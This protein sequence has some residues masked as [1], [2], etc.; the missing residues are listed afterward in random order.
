MPRHRLSHFHR[1]LLV[2]VLYVVRHP[3]RVLI[4]AVLGV[5]FAAGLAWWRLNVSTDQNR[6]F[7]S[8]VPFFK[9]YLAFN[10]DFPE[11]EANYVLVQAKDP[12]HWPAV[13]RWAAVSD[14]ITDA[15]RKRTDAVRDVDNRVPLESLHGQGLLYESHALLKQDLRDTKQLVPLARQWGE[16]PRGIQTLLGP[17][18][19]ERW[20]SGLGLQN[21]P[22]VQAAQLTGLMAE[23][24]HQ[25]IEQPNVP[26]TLGNQVPDLSRLG[27]SDPSRL[28]YNYTEDQEDILHGVPNPRHLLLIRVVQTDS[29]GSL[30]GLEQS[31]DVI[32]ETAAAAAKP[33]PEF[34]VDLT[35]R[36]VLEADEMS[37]TDRD[38]TI[39]EIVALSA[40]FIGLVLL[41]RSIWLAVAAELALLVGIGWTFGWATV[42]TMAYTRSS[43]GELNLLSAVF[44]I[45]LIGIGMDYLIQVLTRY[46][47]ESN[48]HGDR[49]GARE[50][51]V[52]WIGVFKYVAAPINTACLG[53]AGAFFVSMFT[54]FRGAAEL[55]LIAS[56]GLL[57]CL[58]TGYIILPA[59]LTLFPARVKAW[60]ET[61]AITAYKPGRHPNRWLISPA[62]WLALLMAGLPFA[63]RTRFDPGLINMQNPQLP[64]VRLV[65]KL[66]MWSDVVLSKDLNV[67]RRVRDKAVTL[68]TVGGTESVLDA[69]DNYDWLQ[70]H[71]SELGDNLKWIDPPSIEYDRIPTIRGKA[72]SLAKKYRD[73]AESAAQSAAADFRTSAASLDRFVADLP[74]AAVTG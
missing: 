11:N 62:L 63:F 71:N 44:L 17:T 25:A 72:S 68:S 54:H 35:G 57:L 69:Q 42:S 55:G 28:G 64:S 2:F 37:T 58:S 73:A 53:A 15:L 56:G 12:I 50:P 23:G 49:E 14:A 41:L 5:A 30:H 52:I 33:F 22:D 36:P 6:L 10:A 40:V 24:W 74:D 38:S 8:N 3:I 43:H 1:F 9:D 27:A 66:Q 60:P 67:L 61:D 4:A 65:N 32:R 26:I 31:I 7:S 16:A 59:L 51:R 39:S 29:F 13:A 47:S 46:R 18:P 45:A 20:I 34:T 70:Q 21:P 48:R 19:L